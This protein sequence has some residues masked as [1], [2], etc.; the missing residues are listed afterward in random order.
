METQALTG[1]R[2]SPSAGTP[3]MAVPGLL[4]L[5]HSGTCGVNR[6]DLTSWSELSIDALK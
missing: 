2:R 4:W 5:Y 3:G 1:G 6:K